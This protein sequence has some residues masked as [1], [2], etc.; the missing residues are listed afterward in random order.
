MTSTNKAH[1]SNEVEGTENGDGNNL[2][3]NQCVLGP[4]QSKLFHLILIENSLSKLIS[5]YK[6]E[7]KRII[8]CCSNSIIYYENNIN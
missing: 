3:S 5:L 6:I 2:W 7:K 8:L 1:T 4:L